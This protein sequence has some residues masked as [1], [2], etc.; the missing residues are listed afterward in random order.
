MVK[1]T[2]TTVIIKLQAKWRQLSLIS[3]N[4][5]YLNVLNVFGIEPKTPPSFCLLTSEFLRPP[6]P[7]TSVNYISRLEGY[8]ERPVFAEEAR[9]ALISRGVLDPHSDPAGKESR[10]FHTAAHGTKM[11]PQQPIVPA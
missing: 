5:D 2:V 3:V 7:A 4:H 9:L 8:R 6:P 1:H 11:S 10:R